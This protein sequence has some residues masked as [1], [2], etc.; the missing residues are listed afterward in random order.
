MTG[1]MIERTKLTLF[2]VLF[3]AVCGLAGTEKPNIVYILCDDLG[4][5]DVQCLVPVELKNAGAPGETVGEQDL[6]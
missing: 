3:S 2:A 1:N 4:Y 6:I 5:G